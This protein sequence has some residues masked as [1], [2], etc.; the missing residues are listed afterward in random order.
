MLGRSRQDCLDNSDKINKI[1]HNFTLIS[2]YQLI[3]R[4]HTFICLFFFLLRKGNSVA[5]E[6]L[7]LS[8]VFDEDSI[9]ANFL[10]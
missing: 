2:M 4:G 7:D 8:Y 10:Q 9:V 6:G 1:R 5:S 3:T